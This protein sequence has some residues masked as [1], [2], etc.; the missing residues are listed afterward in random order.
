MRLRNALL[1]AHTSI[2]LSYSSP[3]CLA[4]KGRVFR[5][6][7]RPV[8]YAR[9]RCWG[10]KRDPNIGTLRNY[11]RNLHN[12]RNEIP[13]PLFY[14]ESYSCSLFREIFNCTAT[15]TCAPFFLREKLKESSR[16]NFIETYFICVQVWMWSATSSISISVTRLFVI[17]KITVNKR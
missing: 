16:T 17:L 13:P 9:V 6:D 3:R 2:L 1:H 4:R 10:K 8:T 5:H 15:I 14:K 12:L 7:V 11:F